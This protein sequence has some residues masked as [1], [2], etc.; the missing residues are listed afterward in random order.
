MPGEILGNS[1]IFSIVIWVI[2]GLIGGSVTAYVISRSITQWKASGIVLVGFY[3]L[4]AI[5][6][7]GIVGFV[8]M[9]SFY[10]PSPGNTSKIAVIVRITLSLAVEGALTGSLGAYLMQ[11]KIQDIQSTQ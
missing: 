3:W 1:I 8:L 9:Q 6:L 7:G 4:A 5:F 11:T 2:P 10:K